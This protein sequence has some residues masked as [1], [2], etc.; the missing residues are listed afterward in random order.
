MRPS[1]ASASIRYQYDSKGNKL[2]ETRISRR[3]KMRHETSYC[4]NFVFENKALKRILV[5]GGFIYF[6]ENDT[7]Y[8]YLLH[9]LHTPA[10]TARNAS[11][12]EYR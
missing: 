1:T 5:D 8:H 11:K 3:P 7:T 10:T 6:G 12:I 4:G 9:G 2:Q